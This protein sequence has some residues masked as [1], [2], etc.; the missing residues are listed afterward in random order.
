MS[1][2]G[3][4]LAGTVVLVG[5][6]C[7]AGCLW[8]KG[9]CELSGSRRGVSISADCSGQAR[10]LMARRPLA[11]QSERASLTYPGRAGE[12]ARTASRPARGL[13]CTG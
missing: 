7:P 9:A 3:E 10:E 1:D 5:M 11:S 13:G 12:V 6:R 8:L 4:E 2:N